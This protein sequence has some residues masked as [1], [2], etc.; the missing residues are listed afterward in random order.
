M[1][2]ADSEGAVNAATV[3]GL[4]ATHAMQRQYRYGAVLTL[5][6]TLVIFQVVAP[7]THIS[8]ALDLALAGAALTV[9]VATSRAQGQVRHKRALLVSVVA[10]LLVVGVATGVF[11]SSITFLVNTLLVALVPVTL[12]GGLLRLVRSEGVTVQVVAGAIAMYL[13][14]GLLFASLIAFVAHVQSRPYFEQGHGTEAT[15]VYYSFAALTTTGFG[16]YTAAMPVGRALAVLEMLTGQLYLVTVIG[17]VIG[18]FA[19]GRLRRQPG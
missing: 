15:D 19:G 4:T 10:L 7:D 14:V 3:S 13:V 17:I 8:R 9:A 1:R 11:G 6:L 12:V 5:I 18:N 2:V 16:D